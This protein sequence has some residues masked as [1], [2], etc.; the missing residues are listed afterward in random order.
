MSKHEKAGRLFA[1][2]NAAGIHPAVL[3]AI[4][5][6]NRGHSLA[7]GNDPWT[8]RATDL[9]RQTFGND[10]DVAFAFGGTGANIVGLAT[11][12][13]SWQ[14]IVCAESS[15][16]WRDEC[17][18][19]ERWLGAKLSPLATA[20]GKLRPG[21]IEP[22]LEDRGFVHRA[23]PRVVSV[24]QPTEW[25]TVYTLDELRA[26]GEFCRCNDLFLHVD[27]ARLANAAAAL[28]VSLRETSVDCGVDVLSFGGTKN[29]LLAGEAILA[30]SPVRSRGLQF[31]LKQGAQL[32]SKM[33]FVAAQF[34]ALLS[35]DLWRKNALHANAM[36]A[37][38]GELLQAI[39]GVQIVQPVETNV[40]FAQVPQAS[41]AA[42]HERFAIPVWR[43]EGPVLRIMTSFD[44]T[45]DDLRE[46]IA[47][48]AGSGSTISESKRP[49]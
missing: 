16:L 41:V 23:Q 25:G 11:L 28:N 48:L 33:R 26:L 24:S 38:L 19:P 10:L 34:E 18:A 39:D 14:S 15:H 30:F 27:G 35:N 44:T 36:A 49:G 4:V 8:A 1:S 7:Y 37:Q 31:Q 6:A 32:A 22:L 17:A 2:D 20:D 47:V 40:V 42:L 5:A 3:E 46:L 29:G 13:E 12:L 21:D 9:M 43:S 45:P